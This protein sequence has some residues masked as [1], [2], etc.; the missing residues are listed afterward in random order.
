MVKYVSMEIKIAVI[1]IWFKLAKNV[2]IFLI[3]VLV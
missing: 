3:L 2:K 1:D